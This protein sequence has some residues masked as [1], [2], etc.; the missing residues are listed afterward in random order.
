MKQ[1]LHKQHFKSLLL[2]VLAFVPFT[3]SAQTYPIAIDATNFPDANFR[4]YLL[5]QDYGKDSVITE[6]EI[7]D[8]RS[9]KVSVKNINRL[10]G[11]EYFTELEE[12]TCMGNLLTSLDISKNTALTSLS[13]GINLLT[14]LDIS[15]NI[16]LTH[17]ECSINK[18]TSLDVSNNIELESISCYRNMIAGE[19]MDA[20]INS[21]P[22]NTTGE[23]YT[24]CISSDD[25]QEGNVCTTDHVAK[26][27]AKGWS[28]ENSLGEKYEGV[29]TG[30]A[31][32]TI[33]NI[34]TNA[35]IYD[36]SG[37]RVNNLQG[38]KGIYIIGGK[39]VLKK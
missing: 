37:K 2:A 35:P 25:K 28:V 29:A 36:L 18:L 15:N 23:R 22:E 19:A 38:K 1:Q 8:I 30:I 24:L 20:F 9:I 4:A 3:V 12:L 39:K 32:Q 21:L 17:L 11:V 16:A 26:A 14:F 34:D 6:N 31:L 13:C 7:K 5:E 10:K 27:T 33:E